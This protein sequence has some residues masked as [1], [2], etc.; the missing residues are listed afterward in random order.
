MNHG[1]IA[2]VGTPAA[3]YESPA[4]KFVADFIGSVN[5]FEGRVLEEG[6]GRI[7][8]DELGCVVAV[9]RALNCGRGT[10]VWTAVRPE[11]I[12]MTR[13]LEQPP[14]PRE[15]AVRGVVKEIAYMGDVSIYIVQIDSGKTVRVTLPNILR[16]A[17]HR[18]GRDEAVYLS[19]HGSSPVVLTE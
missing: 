2:Q 10:T 19:W 14:G 9:D 11:K 1:R 5:M 4:T 12:N 17:D 7:H 15:N 6:T 8:S 16:D 3:I 18:I 13:A